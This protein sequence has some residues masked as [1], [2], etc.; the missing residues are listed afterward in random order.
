MRAGDWNINVAERIFDLALLC[1]TYKKG[2]RPF[3]HS[4]NGVYT[5]LKNILSEIDKKE[6]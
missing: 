5:L 1:I 4:E 3:M 6:S 2:E